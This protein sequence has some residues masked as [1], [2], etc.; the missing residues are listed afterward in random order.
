VVFAHELGHHVHRHLLKL[1][2]LHALASVIMFALIYLVLGPFSGPDPTLVR[3]A[4]QRLPLMALVISLFTFFWR[5]ISNAVSRHFEV[6]CDAYALD[7][8]R[9]PEH[10]ARAFELLAEQNLADPS[11]PRWVVWLYYAHPPIHERIAMARTS[12]PPI[13]DT[14]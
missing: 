4:V 14:R 12:M 13:P 10:F 5:P 9:A 2:G 3:D 8:T 1:L 6:Q 11:P 7:R